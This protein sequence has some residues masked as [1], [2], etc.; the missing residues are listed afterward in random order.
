MNTLHQCHWQS[1]EHFL[2]N[3]TM[4]SPGDSLLVMGEIDQQS[5]QLIQQS[6]APLGINWYLVNMTNEPHIVPN[7]IN[8][9]DWLKLI[10][11]HQS[12]FSWK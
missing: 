5:H 12:I 8:H 1:A 7:H 9:D 6:M 3:M 11:K 10:I 2:T 4:I